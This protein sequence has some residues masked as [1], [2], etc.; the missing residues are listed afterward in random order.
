M[1]IFVRKEMRERQHQSGHVSSEKQETPTELTV[2]KKITMMM[3]VIDCI[4]HVEDVL[5]RIEWFR[6][7]LQNLQHD[8]HIVPKGMF[9]MAEL[10]NL[11]TDV[12]GRI[13]GFL[14]IFAIMI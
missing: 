12:H 8:V 4:H 5:V 2:L 9:G 6:A 10:A 1:D 11:C 14:C 7:L 3:D 13:L